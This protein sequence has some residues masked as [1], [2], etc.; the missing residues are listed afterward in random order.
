[1]WMLAGALVMRTGPQERLAVTG[2]AR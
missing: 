1:V 2:T